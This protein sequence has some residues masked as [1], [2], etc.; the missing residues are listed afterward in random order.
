[1]GDAEVAGSS[2]LPTSIAAQFAPEL[3]SALV[4]LRRAIHED[5][6]LSFEENRT[7]ERLERPLASV[8]ITD[9]R[10]VARTGVISRVRGRN[11]SAPVVAV[12]GDIDALPV[13]EET[14]LSFASRNEGVMHACGH[15]VHAT[16]A[17]GAAALL[18][19]QPA[20]G[21]VVVLL[22]PA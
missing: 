6:E 18:A 9:V 14:G 12:R 2:V 17:V 7:A 22:Q 4:A 8:G 10:L 1:M 20:A 15:D 5:P 13:R 11:S 19:R 3:R 21:D 16:W